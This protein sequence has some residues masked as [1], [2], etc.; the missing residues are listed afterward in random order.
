VKEV[1]NFR[2]VLITNFVPVHYVTGTEQPTPNASGPAPRSLVIFG[3]G[4]IFVC[5]QARLC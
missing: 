2:C 5:L 1:L 3:N 4:I